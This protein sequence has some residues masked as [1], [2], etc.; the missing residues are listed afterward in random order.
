MMKEALALACQVAAIRALTLSNK[1]SG[2][3]TQRHET[4]AIRSERKAGGGQ[5]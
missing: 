4:R 3:N 2:S 1:A 5:A